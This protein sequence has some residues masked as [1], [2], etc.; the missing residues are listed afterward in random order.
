[1]SPFEADKKIFVILNVQNMNESA[2]N[3]ILKSIEEPPKN[4]FYILCA[5]SVSRILQTILSRVKRIELDELLV[6]D[7]SSM[8][9]S[10]GVDEQKALIY[11]SCA[12]GNGEFAEKLA[13]DDGFIDFFNQIVTCL[14]NINGSRDVLNYASIFTSKAVDKEE[15]FNIAMLLFRDIMMI[16]TETPEFV[17]CK[18]VLAKLKVISSTLNIEAVQTMIDV[19][20]KE[21]EKLHFNVSQTA[22][23]DDFLL[24]LA[25]VKVK[26]RRL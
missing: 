4:T 1:M 7:I 11:A 6:A 26:C 24:K 20:L 23:V 18:N 19:C 21:K 25:E 15:F 3:K 5:N 16:L 8:L 17:I 10:K 9:I 12:N 2:Q 22:V 13:T 14:Y